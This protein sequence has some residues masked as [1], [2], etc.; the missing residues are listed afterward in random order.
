MPWSNLR[1]VKRTIGRFLELAKSDDRGVAAVEFAMIVPIMFVLFVGSVEFSQAITVD[2]RVTQ[3]AS[4]TA[5]LVAR[6]KSTSTSEMNGIMEIIAQLMAP[7]SA[8]PLK[9]TILNVYS[10]PN[11]ASDTKVCWSYNHNG[12]AVNYTNGQ[13]YSLPTGVVQAGESVI[14]ADVTY[15]YTPLIFD[16]FIKSATTFTETFYLKPRL[17][18]SVEYNGYKCL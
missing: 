12:G 13:S 18:S 16:Y 5:D 11:N 15:T 7:Y 3:V 17:S 1:F 10:D 14:V 9:L 6:T 8:T 2:R 4:S